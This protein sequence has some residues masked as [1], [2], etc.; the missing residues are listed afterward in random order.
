MQINIVFQ[1]ILY[2]CQ[3]VKQTWEINQDDAINNVAS[4]DF[5]KMPLELRKAW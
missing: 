1:Q 3:F 5:Q 2:A 4:L